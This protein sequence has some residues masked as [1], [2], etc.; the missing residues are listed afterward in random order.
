[1]K[2]LIIRDA[3]SALPVFLKWWEE[4]VDSPMHANPC[5]PS[6]LKLVY[7]T[8]GFVTFDRA[9]DRLTPTLISILKKQADSTHPLP[10]LHI[11]NCSPFRHRDCL[12][13]RQ[14]APGLKLTWDGD[15]DGEDS[16]EEEDSDGEQDSD[17]EEDSSSDED[18]DEV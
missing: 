3:Y 16:D 1:M 12:C 8:L 18:S 10:E 15:G 4:E 14:A 13:A 9:R 17:D 6:L 2:T 7:E 5:F 11:K